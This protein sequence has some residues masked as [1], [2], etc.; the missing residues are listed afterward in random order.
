VPI[1]LH[2]DGLPMAAQLVGPL[3][4]DRLVLRAARALEQARPWKLPA[5]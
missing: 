4:A 5:S 3:Y 2:A 1:G